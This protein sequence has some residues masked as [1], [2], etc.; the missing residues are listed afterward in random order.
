MRRP[1]QNL[2]GRILS[3]SR[4]EADPDS[5]QTSGD[6]SPYAHDRSRVWAASAVLDGVDAKSFEL[7]HDHVYKDAK[8]VYV[9]TKAREVLRADAA[10]FVKVAPL[11]PEASALFRDRFRHYVYEPSY[12]EIY[13]LEPRAD[14]IL[15]WKAVW[16]GRAEAPEVAHGATVSAQLK[17]GVLSE[18]ELVLEPAFK[19]EKPP[20]W[21]KDKLKL[22]KP[23]FVAAQKEMSAEKKGTGE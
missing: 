8:R 13:A 21:E 22:L 4:L 20:T 11:Q 9:G 14:A 18:P 15:I 5:F 2:Q 10:S 17:D 23:L 3:P 6:E 7:L 19:E 12:V 16:W 1:N